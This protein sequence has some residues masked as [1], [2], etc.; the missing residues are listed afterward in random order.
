[1]QVAATDKKDNEFIKTV[2]IYQGTGFHENEMI[3]DFGWPVQYIASNFKQ[4]YPFQ[5]PMCIDMTGQT[6]KEVL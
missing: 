5:K 4:Y 6:I 1:M 2:S 3:I